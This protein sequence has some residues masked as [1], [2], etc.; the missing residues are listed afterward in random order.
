M[1]I[2]AQGVCVRYG[3]RDVLSEISCTF[4]AGC[5]TGV[6][7]PNGS[8]KTTLLRVLSGAQPPHAGQVR[9]D[10]NELGGICCKR[11]AQLM[12]VVPQKSSL[13]FDFT[14]MDIVLMGR[15]PFL[16]RF[17][18][19]N[20]HDVQL[21][22]RSM[23]RVGLL[24][25]KDRNARQLSGG[26]WQR[27]MIARALCQDTPILLMDEPFSNLD[28]R[29]QM[30]SLSVIRALSREGRLCL[31]VLHDL[32]LAAHYCDRLLLLHEGKI[33]AWGSPAQV[34]TGERI[35]AVYGVNAE[36][37]CTQDQKAEVRLRYDA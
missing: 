11:R 7:G 21:A 12:A 15:E 23:D 5:L 8:G 18:R 13:D 31:V 1:N 14:V 22:L 3:G 30:R 36:V 19:E 28:V 10:G 29:Y 6:I 17:E 16:G 4:E 33:C 32:N 9:V 34:L 24:P 25:M 26:E 27:V 37:V 35:Q 2:C 20:A